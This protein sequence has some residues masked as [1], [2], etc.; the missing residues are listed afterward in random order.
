M[1]DVYAT[2]ELWFHLQDLAQESREDL[3]KAGEIKPPKQKKN[4]TN[5]HKD[6][7]KTKGKKID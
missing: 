3:V 2:T 4:S 7:V 1:T 5:A 6:N